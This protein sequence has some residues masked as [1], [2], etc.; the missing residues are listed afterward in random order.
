MDVTGRSRRR[1]SDA[2]DRLDDQFGVD[3]CVEERWAVSSDE[4]ERTRARFE[5]GTLGGAGAWIAREDGAVLLLREADRDGWADPGGKHEPGESLAET[6]RREV[7]EETGIDVSLRG[8]A[9][10]EQ[11][12]HCDRTDADRPPI[13]RLVIVFAGH[14]V[15]GTARPSEPG[16]EAVCWF[17][18]HPD[19]LLYDALASLPIPAPW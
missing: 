2:L 16:I 7:R 13:H 8:V 3:W 9:L 11:A 14:Q 10:A 4:Y 6:A 5:E 12:I 15:G 17:Q 19:D 1:V 18:E